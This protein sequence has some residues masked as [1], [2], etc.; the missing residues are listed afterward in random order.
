M[1][2]A[3]PII[4]LILIPLAADYEVK[5]ISISIVDN[6]VS[7]FSRRLT[8]KIKSS[9]IFLLSDYGQDY[10]AALKSVGKS[11]SDLILSIELG[12]EKNLIRVWTEF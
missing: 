11:K 7:S 12:F 1:I 8:E 9:G 2:L 6:D 10:N 5:N 3:M 4:Q